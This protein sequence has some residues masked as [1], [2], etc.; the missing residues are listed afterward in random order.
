MAGLLGG[1]L[2]RDLQQSVQRITQAIDGLKPILEDNTR[3]T[4]ANTQ[5]MVDVAK[6]AQALEID[7]LNLEKK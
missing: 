5:E 3:E 2:R 1:D 7:I 4:R 6:E